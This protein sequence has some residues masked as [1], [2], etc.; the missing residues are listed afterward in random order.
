MRSWR[1][2]AAVASATALLA[3]VGSIAA[4]SPSASG[5]ASVHT[6]K[7]VAVR[8]GHDHP[9]GKSSFVSSEVEK[10]NGNVIGTDSVTGHVNLTTGVAKIWVAV[11]WKGGTVI[12]RGH[13]TQTTPF[14]GRLVRGTGKYTGIEGTVTTRD[15]GHGRTAVTVHY[16]LP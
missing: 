8:I 6:R 11:A 2:R 4:F 3:G 16:T 14:V 12:V 13:A 5:A 9:I 10:H 15:L 7:F 1:F